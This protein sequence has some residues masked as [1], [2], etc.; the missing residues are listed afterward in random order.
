MKLKRT[1]ATNI[2]TNVIAPVE[3]EML[4]LKLTSSKFS[5]MIDESTDVAC[6][7]TMCV[8]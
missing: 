1:K 7:S 5:I 4:S 8:E 6:I 2:I 3:K